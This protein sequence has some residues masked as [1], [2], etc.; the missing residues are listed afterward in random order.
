MKIS[1]TLLLTVLCTLALVYGVTDTKE[2]QV[3]APGPDHADERPV[4]KLKRA[5]SSPGLGKRIIQEMIEYHDKSGKTGN[6]ILRVVENLED[7]EHRILEAGLLSKAGV[8]SFYKSHIKTI[9]F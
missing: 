2:A 4:D 8:V 9:L 7:Y 6:H 1:L 5:L 3:K